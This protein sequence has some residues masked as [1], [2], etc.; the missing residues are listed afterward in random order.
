MKFEAGLNSRPPITTSVSETNRSNS[1]YFDWNYIKTNYNN[2]NHTVLSVFA[3]VP[4][5]GR[6]I[7]RQFDWLMITILRRWWWSAT[8]GRG[9]QRASDQLEACFLMGYHVFF[10]FYEI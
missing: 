4:L 6:C 9:L 3:A 10:F 5:P 8:T 2:I 7:A 1:P